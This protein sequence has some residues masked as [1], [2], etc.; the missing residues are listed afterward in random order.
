[1]RSIAAVSLALSVAAI[2]ILAAIL[3][4]MNRPRRI[5]IVIRPSPQLPQELE[6]ELTT[7]SALA[8]Y[9]INLWVRTLEQPKTRAECENLLRQE[10]DI[11]GVELDPDP[12]TVRS[13]VEAVEASIR[14]SDLCFERCQLISGRCLDAFSLGYLCGTVTLLAETISEETEAKAKKTMADC[15]NQAE[16][17]TR[18]LGLP[19]EVSGGAQELRRKLATIENHKDYPQFGEDTWLWFQSA[20][21]SL[22]DVQKQPFEP[23]LPESESMTV[24]TL[25]P[26]AP[27]PACGFF[28]KEGGQPLF[29]VK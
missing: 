20:Y 1:M 2:V 17:A 26:Q 5:I 12:A 3:V 28:N 8:G 7:V 22:G 21:K 14:Y 19:E 29:L 18:R 15:I 25:C 24:E 13:H 27:C 4:D 6:D 9:Q 11:L 16:A 23:S 10:F